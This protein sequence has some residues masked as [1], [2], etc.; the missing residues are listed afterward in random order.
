MTRV[1]S[2][3]FVLPLLTLFWLLVALAAFLGLTD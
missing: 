3:R 1:P 2:V